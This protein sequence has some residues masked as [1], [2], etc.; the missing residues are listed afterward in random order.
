[1]THPFHLI[2]HQTPYWLPIPLASI[3]YDQ[4]ILNL[5]SNIGKEYESALISQAKNTL[6]FVNKWFSLKW[7]NLLW[8]APW[9]TNAQTTQI[10]KFQYARYLGTYQKKN[11]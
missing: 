7:A 9:I 1:M 5:K 10:L 8:D 6:P 11:L 4:S 2:R 3:Q